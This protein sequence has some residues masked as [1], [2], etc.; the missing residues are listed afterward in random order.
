MEEKKKIATRQSYGEALAEL[1]EKNKEIVVLDADL[2]GATKTSIFA[3]KNPERFFD[4]G[5]AEQDMIGTA[6][7]MAT[8]GKIPYAST[9]AMFAAGRAYDQIRNSICYPKLNVKICA[10]HCGITVGEDGATHQMLEDIGLMRGL[11]N[12]TVISTSDDVQTRWAVKEISKLK[13]PVYMRLCRLET[14]VIYDENQKFEIG[15]AIQIGECNDGT[16]FET[17]VVVNEAIKAKEEL[18]KQ[19][20]NIRVVDIHTIKPIDEETIIKCAKETKK[21]VSIEDH[22]VINGLGTAISDVLTEKYPTKL[23]KMGIQDEF[24]RSGKATELL[25]YYGLTA[26]GIIH[27]IING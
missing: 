26:D 22:S 20:I 5:I 18:E 16:V 19:G 23:I 3:K 15:K 17:G 12:M 14:P 9:F 8:F 1:G 24:G 25:E 27:Q 6:A 13:G 11:P 7:G 4:I 10:T 21:L 2:S